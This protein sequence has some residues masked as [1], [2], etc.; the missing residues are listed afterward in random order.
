MKKITAFISFIV[1]IS[2]VASSERMR[3]DDF[4]KKREYIKALRS[5][6]LALTQ[7]T[8][9]SQRNEIQQKI[10]ET[11]V[12]IVDDSIQRAEFVYQKVDPPSLQSIEDA[13]L[14]LKSSPTDDRLGRIS[15]QIKKYQD[16]KKGII[17]SEAE[18]MKAKG[19]Y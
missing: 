10:G 12:K 14:V 3:A 17:K 16:I 19:E 7:S 9:D 5:Y 15:S 11:K 1:I 13:I 6:E 8:T 4:Y 2:C 18:R